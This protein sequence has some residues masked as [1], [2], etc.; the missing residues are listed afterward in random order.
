MNREIKLKTIETDIKKLGDVL[1]EPAQTITE[2][3]I[4]NYPIFIAHQY[5]LNM[6]IP[7]IDKETVGTNWS[8]NAS[9]L[10][11]LA[12]KN[13]I[14]GEKLENFRQIYKSPQDFVCIFIVDDASTEFLFYPYEEEVAGDAVS[15]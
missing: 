2:Q 4:S 9:T 3:D 13:I 7:L 15:D 8:L 12:T 11:E 10:E 1:K 6:G 5:S 14:V